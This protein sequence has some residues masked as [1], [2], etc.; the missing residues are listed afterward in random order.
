EQQPATYL[1]G[2]GRV[3]GV[4]LPDEHGPD[5]LLEEGQLLGRD[6]LLGGRLLLRLSREGRGAGRPENQPDAEEESGD[7]FHRKLLATRDDCCWN[8]EPREDARVSLPEV[9]EA[10]WQGRRRH[11]T[12]PP[13]VQESVRVV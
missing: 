8:L 11:P 2:G 5:T 7:D 9:D 12:P 3:A 10:R 4:A 1:L 6:R 13:G